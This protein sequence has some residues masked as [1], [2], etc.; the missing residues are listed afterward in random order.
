MKKYLVTSAD[1]AVILKRLACQ[2]LENHLDF[3]NSV[4]IGLQPRGVH[5]ASRIVKILQ[6]QV[7]LKKISIGFL[8]HTFYRDDF[9]RR[10]E[11][12]SPNT[13]KIPFLVEGKK[14]ILLDDVLFSGRSV[15]AALKA[16]QAYG[17]P[18]SVELLVLIDRRFSR[19]LPIQPDYVG[20]TVDAVGNERVLV[21]WKEDTGEDAIFLKEQ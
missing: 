9:R 21:T 1:L 8:D 10:A 17:R 4:L 13:T 2:I 19:N 16:L 12:L 7:G 15:N 6:K 20:R 11:P 5:F 3:K 18:A 14:V